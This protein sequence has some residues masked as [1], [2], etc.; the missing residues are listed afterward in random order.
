MAEFCGAIGRNLAQNS[1][2]P[3]LEPQ[4]WRRINRSSSGKDSVSSLSD[5]GNSSSSWGSRGSKGS[6]GNNELMSRSD[7]DPS[8]GTDE[9]DSDLL[10]DEG[11]N[12]I[13][14]GIWPGT[15]N[16]HLL[17]RFFSS[18]FSGDWTGYLPFARWADAW[19]MTAPGVP[20]WLDNWLEEKEDKVVDD[21]GN[22]GGGRLGSHGDGLGVNTINMCNKTCLALPL[23]HLGSNA[24]GA[25]V[26][27]R[28]TP[29]TKEGQQSLLAIWHSDIWRMFPPVARKLTP[30]EQARVLMMEE[31]IAL[32]TREQQA[33]A[34]QVQALWEK[35][36]AA[37][38]EK[39]LPAQEPEVC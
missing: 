29:S 7:G 5:E 13:L 12:E 3:Y 9:V 30:Q 10:K 31:E 24:S 36:A 18:H 27:L 26:Y 2:S 20:I 38:N 4:R 25:T 17:T 1:A 11:K 28:S 21:R 8:G 15:H 32:Q 14:E 22:A 16:P 23:A 33:V 6:R 34:R 39:C 37:A 19:S 35:F